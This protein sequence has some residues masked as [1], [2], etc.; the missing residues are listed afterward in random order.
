MTL[1]TLKDAGITLGAP[2]FTQLDLTLHA[3]D[4]LAVV[5][6]NGRGKTT[7]LRVIA[8]T[9]DLTTGE[10]TRRHGLVTATLSQEMPPD[11]APLTVLAAVRAAAIRSAQS[12]RPAKEIP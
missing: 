6:A 11:L 7:L 9:S 10:I 8:G 4:R 12:G 2:L 3:G 5:A 1:L